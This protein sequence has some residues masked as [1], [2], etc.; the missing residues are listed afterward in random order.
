MMQPQLVQV[1]VSAAGMHPQYQSF[2]GMHMQPAPMHQVHFIILC[3]FFLVCLL[4]CVGNTSHHVGVPYP[5]CHS[6]F[7]THY[8]CACLTLTCY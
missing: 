5:F 8:A 4:L 6:L 2:D 7:R 1:P 3:S